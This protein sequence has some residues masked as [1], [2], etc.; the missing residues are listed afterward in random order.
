MIKS[1]FLK[2]QNYDLFARNY[3]K[4]KKP[5][6]KNDGA[7]NYSEWIGGIIWKF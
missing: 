5:S 6:S 4:R 7:F 3:N 2:A 1:D